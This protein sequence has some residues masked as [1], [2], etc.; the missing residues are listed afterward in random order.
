MTQ[1]KSKASFLD[2]VFSLLKKEESWCIVISADPDALGAAMALKRIIGRRVARVTIAAVNEITRPDNLAMIR[3]LR[4]PVKQW[5][6]EMGGMFD[7]FAMV[8]SQPHHNEAFKNLKF[9]LII[10]HHPLQPDGTT[11]EERPVSYIHPEYGATCTI[12]TRALEYLKI[13]P[14]RLLATAMLYGIR[15]DTAAFERAG[16]EADLRAYQYLTRYADMI[17]LRRIL[18]SE[19]LIQWLP[20][21][22]KAM[23]S[24]HTTKNK[25]CYAFVGKVTSS[26]ILVAIADFF[27]RIH[28]LRWVAIA[29]CY[30][31]RAVIVFRSDGSRDIGQ[32]ASS[33]F[34]DLGGAG[35]HKTM[36]R[37][38]F[39]PPVAKDKLGIFIQSRLEKNCE[40]ACTLLAAP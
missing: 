10:D 32:F 8:D 27:T 34:G 4:I 3:Y 7:H 2:K 22:S 13:K 18:R 6:P 17:L 31:G 38:E 35:G 23:R 15:T 11:A 21:F 9:S 5:I 36:A 40:T 12:F 20:W 39:D 16:G 19:Y 1:G 14:G 25:G 26:D 24:L 29:G 37:A 28:G 33:R 30:K